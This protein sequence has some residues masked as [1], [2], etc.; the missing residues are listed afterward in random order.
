MHAD[1]RM[2]PLDLRLIATALAET[3][4]KEVPA[5]TRRSSAVVAA[6][7]TVL[8]VCWWIGGVRTQDMAVLIAGYVCF[9]SA[10][11][12][13]AR[14]AR[15]PTFRRVIRA[16]NV[17]GTVATFVVAGLAM[18]TAV[19][20]ATA[21][22][23]AFSS[24]VGMTTGGFWFSPEPIRDLSIAAALGVSAIGMMFLVATAALPQVGATRVR[25]RRVPVIQACWVLTQL[26][27]V[28]AATAL[29]MSLLQER[30]APATRAEFDFRGMLVGVA[31]LAVGAV[32][33]WN[34][35]NRQLIA[36]ERRELLALLTAA[37]HQLRSD[38]PSVAVT[39]GQMQRLTHSSATLRRSVATPPLASFEIVA[40]IDSLYAAASE[41]HPPPA[42]TTRARGMTSAEG[43]IFRAALDAI[44]KHPA[45]YLRAGRGLI[46][47]LRWRLLT[48]RVGAE[49]S[50]QSWAAFT[51]ARPEPPLP[52]PPHHPRS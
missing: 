19:L 12:F 27:V 3:P 22:A 42:L 48:G 2:D 6:G 28:A 10:V 45:E 21:A 49:T 1:N 40:V 36:A 17:V 11:A 47:D 30:L 34:Y 52:P 35:R 9:V 31:S 5:R 23:A 41:G 29:L 37:D 32:F 14:A 43:D 38:D 13:A 46:T 51:P 39:F 26:V 7:L 4:E 15:L 20:A 33:A 25:M 50:T 18:L 16:L 8:S 44:A 24:S